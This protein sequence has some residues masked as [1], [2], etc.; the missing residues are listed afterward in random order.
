MWSITKVVFLFAY[1]SLRLIF[2]TSTDLKFFSMKVMVFQSACI[3][4]LMIL[5]KQNK[6]LKIKTN[7]ISK[8]VF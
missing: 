3:V 6:H 1:L 8:G 7:F 5:T 4:Y 2:V